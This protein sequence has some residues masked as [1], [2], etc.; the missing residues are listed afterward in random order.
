MK[1]RIDRDN[2]LQDILAEEEPAGFREDLLNQTLQLAR[3]RRQFRQ[4]RAA[5]L[6]TLLILTL[7]LVVRLSRT[8]A[9][10]PIQS[11]KVYVVRTEPPPPGTFLET[12]LLPPE[13]LVVSIASANTVATAGPGSPPR[14]IDDD[15]L[16]ELASPNPVV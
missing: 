9:D 13:R 3:R 15:E 2:L 14:E 8:P 6:P 12:K 1:H 16:L 7:L 5:V 10:F 4:A 11:F